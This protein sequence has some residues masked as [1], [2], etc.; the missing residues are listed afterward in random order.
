MHV[1]RRAEIADRKTTPRLGPDL[2][3]SSVLLRSLSTL[4]LPSV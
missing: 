2:I 1:P 3:A 4:P